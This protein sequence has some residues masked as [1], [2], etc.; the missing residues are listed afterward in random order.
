MFSDNSFERNI[1]QI[2]FCCS[3]YNHLLRTFRVV[4]QLSEVKRKLAVLRI[5]LHIEIRISNPVKLLENFKICLS[6][7][8]VDLNLILKTFFLCVNGK[9]QCILKH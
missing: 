9:F 1:S 3:K 6:K 8:A 7:T 4:K 2:E 5:M